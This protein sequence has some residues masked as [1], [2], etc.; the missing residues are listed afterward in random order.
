MRIA[1][2]EL[3]GLRNLK[4]THLSLGPRFNLFWGDNAQGKTNLL[5]AV[6]L[7]GDLQGFR[8]ADAEALIAQGGEQAWL[9][10]FA[11]VDGLDYQVALEFT[12]KGRR[13]KVNGKAVSALKDFLGRLPVVSFI[14]DDVRLSKGQPEARRRFLD[15]ALFLTAP[16][17]GA[18]LLAYRQVLK[19][20]NMLLRN[21][22][23]H[24]ASFA[25]YSEQ[26]AGLGAEIR[27][28]RCGLIDELERLVRVHVSQVS[29]A[30]EDVTLAYRSR[31][32]PA[33]TAEED[34]AALLAGYAE[35]AVV[36][37]AR[38]YT[39]LGPHADDLDI[40]LNGLL[41]ADY[42]SQGQH[43]TLA[44]AL[45]LAELHVIHRQR[46]IYP[47]LLI[48]DLSSELD[49]ARRERLFSVLGETSGQVLLT[50]TEAAPASR[51]AAWRRF[52]VRAGEILPS[53][54]GEMP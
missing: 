4:P 39:T 42:A 8:Q 25:I 18:T 27:L 33:A 46:G 12:A 3:S 15:R 2:L 31:V 11:T 50:S 36:D 40:R 30:R 23:A 51:A 7:L 9:R 19:R 38:G 26:L 34:K 48:D 22:R 54:S 41:A 53:D 5:E 52:T 6:S 37:A 1:E 47:V 28:A 16:A 13:L 21:D 10:A 14:P 29:D 17:H 24:D 45:K 49:E 44:L 43:R 32:P 35:R 20:R